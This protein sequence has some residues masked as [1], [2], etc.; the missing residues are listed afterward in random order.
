MRLPLV[1]DEEGEYVE[2]LF[3]PC[4]L[5]DGHILVVLET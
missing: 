2:K 5:S 3:L 1:V 4:F